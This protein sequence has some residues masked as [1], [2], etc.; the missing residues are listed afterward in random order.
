MCDSVV[1]VDERF[2]SPGCSLALHAT[3]FPCAASAPNLLSPVQKWQE[4]KSASK[5]SAAANMGC[6]APQPSA[7]ARA[8][9][10]WHRISKRGRNALLTMNI[11]RVYV[12]EDHILEFLDSVRS[13]FQCEAMFC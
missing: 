11:E 10:A 5:R 12:L 4:H 6:T 3:C 1:Y 8:V 7:A 13:L 9:Q 2:Y